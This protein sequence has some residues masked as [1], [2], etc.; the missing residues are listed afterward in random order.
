MV[1]HTSLARW[2]QLLVGLL[3]QSSVGLMRLILHVFF[4]I[5]FLVFYIQKTGIAILSKATDVTG[6]PE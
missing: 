1:W 6:W 5:F 4:S 2:S 3:K